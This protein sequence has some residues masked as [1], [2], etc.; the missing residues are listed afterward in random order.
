MERLAAVEAP[1]VAAEDFLM[2]FPSGGRNHGAQPGITNPVQGAGF[3]IGRAALGAVQAARVHH[4]AAFGAENAVVVFPAAAKKVVGPQGQPAHEAQRDHHPRIQQGVGYQV[5]RPG[6][7]G[8]VHEGFRADG[9]LRHVRKAAHVF[10]THVPQRPRGEPL[11]YG[12][13]FSHDLACM[14]GSQYRQD[15]PP[16]SVKKACVIQHT[17]SPAE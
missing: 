5:F 2:P 12:N 16:V 6:V 11:L 15:F 8:L 10:F 1:P 13:G 4:G 7:V 9:V 14:Q 3:G 17:A